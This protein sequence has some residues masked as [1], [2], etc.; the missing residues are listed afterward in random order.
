MKKMKSWILGLG[1]LVSNM[2]FAQ[3]VQDGLNFIDRHQPNRAK[4]V[5]ESLVASA[6]TGENYFYLGYYFLHRRDWDSAKAAFEKGRLADPK[7]FLNQVGLASILVGQNNVN[8]AKV[9][10][11][12]IL[13]ETKNKNPE[14]LYR[15]AEAYEMY[16]ILGKE[17]S[18]NASNND[19]AE[20]IRLIDL[21]QEKT[22]KIPTPEQY[23][24][25]GDAYLIKN[26]GGNAVT[27]YEQAVLQDP[28]NVKA[29]IKIGVVYLRGKNYKET[30][31][32]YKEALDIDSNYAP[33]IKRYG[34]Y[35]IVGNQY[36][37]ASRYFR[38]YLEKAEATPEV[39]LETAKLLF[40]SKDYEGAMKYTGEAESKGVKDNDIFRMRG[41]SHVEMGNFQQGIDNL[42]G[43]VKR[44][45][46]PF[47]QDDIYF[48]KGYQG[49]GK[50][51][52]AIAFFEKAAP[53]DTNN[54]IYSMIHDIRYK[55]K[56]YSDASVAARNSIDWKKK[57]NQVVGSGDYFKVA[58]DL[59]LTAAYINRADTIARPAMAMRADSMFA[60]AIEVN[61]KWPPFYINRA[62]ANNFV[63]FTGTKWLGR[64]NYE[65][66]LTAVETQKADKA[67]QYKE[68]KNQMFE[69]YKY[70]GGYHLSVTKDEAKAKEL[71]TKAQ[72]I[73]ADDPDIKAYFN[74]E[75]APKK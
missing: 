37:N 4:Q 12:R 74:P 41:Y 7:N 67:S 75:P 58:M 19:P 42:D 40:L 14:I 27:A 66:F 51:S 3:T 59:Y 36:K 53:L 2:A 65:K 62:R 6:P 68:D 24:V 13:A 49:L 18:F 47:Y 57:K 15:I 11:D 54:N 60:K 73:K 35:L 64:E 9:E 69:A 21:I 71:F 28:K 22:K 44:G 8:A 5:F 1:L 39:T 38:K 32:R 46:K 23:I 20:A 10:F 55:Q 45:V 63:D 17:D 31:A 70:L 52:L 50:D 26:D 72:E 56:R 29:K 61:D 34:E 48:G 25:K 30:Q 16:Y 33:G 43:M